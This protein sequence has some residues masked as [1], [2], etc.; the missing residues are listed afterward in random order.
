MPVNVPSLT[1]LGIPEDIQ[2]IIEC[3]EQ[4]FLKIH[5]RPAG[6]SDDIFEHGPPE[7]LVWPIVNAGKD[8]PYKR[9]NWS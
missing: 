8:V 7:E 1:E 9:E 4:R 6:P 3:A 2:A 5:D